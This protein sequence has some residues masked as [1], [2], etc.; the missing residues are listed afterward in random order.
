MELD[1]SRQELIDLI[2]AYDEYIQEAVMLDR[3]ASGWRPV[4]VT[5]FHNE[6]YLMD[7]SG[8]PEDYEDI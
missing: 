8:E 5:E 4:N 1:L 7:T 6:V 3:F 2:D